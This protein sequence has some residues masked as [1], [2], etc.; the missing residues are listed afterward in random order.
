MI[1]SKLKWPGAFHRARVNTG[2]AIR[3]EL[4]ASGLA[5]VVWDEGE[6]IRYWWKERA[7]AMTNNEAEYAAVIL[8]LE[9]LLGLPFLNRPREVAIYSDSR[10]VVDQMRG[11]ATARTPR[12]RVVAIKLR[13]LVA[14]FERVTFQYIPREQNRLA[15]ALANEVFNP[16]LTHLE[17][18]AEP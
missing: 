5:A 2:G 8:A 18:P 7:G 12:I 13:G 14:R 17:K 9:R 6:A 1:F 16:D 3:P 4:G 10:L 15:D 11:L